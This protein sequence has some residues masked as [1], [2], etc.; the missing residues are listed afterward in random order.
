MFLWIFEENC[1]L[2]LNE[3]IKS[4]KPDIGACN[5]VLDGCFC[6]MGSVFDTRRVRKTMS[7][8]GLSLDLQSCRLLAYL[9]AWKGLES[10]IA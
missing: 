8:L 5:A 3:K 9:Y 4:M 7:I 10:W 1:C 2:A 6:D